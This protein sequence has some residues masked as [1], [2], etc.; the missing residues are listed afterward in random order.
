MHDLILHC[1]EHFLHI[2]EPQL[3]RIV[4][5]DEVRL[6]GCDRVSSDACAPALKKAFISRT[7]ALATSDGSSIG[8]ATIISDAKF[9]PAREGPFARPRRLARSTGYAGGGQSRPALAFV[10]RAFHA[11]IVTQK[12]SA[13]ATARRGHDAQEP[14]SAAQVATLN[15]PLELQQCPWIC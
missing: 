10:R 8:L 7:K 1:D 5:L 11:E 15:A 3:A 13:A 9:P 2:C 4:L 12:D 14:M 6:L